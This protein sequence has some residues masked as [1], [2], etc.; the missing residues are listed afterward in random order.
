MKKIS[1]I[2]IMLTTTERTHKSIV[3]TNTISKKPSRQK[4]STKRERMNRHGM[5]K[6]LGKHDTG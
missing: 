1:R 4:I 5:E 3:N 2:V 6:F